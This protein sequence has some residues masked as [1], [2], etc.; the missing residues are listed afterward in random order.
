MQAVNLNIGGLLQNTGLLRNRN[1]ISR[2]PLNIEATATSLSRIYQSVWRQ[3]GS[4]SPATINQMNDILRDSMISRRVVK[5]SEISINYDDAVVRI[6]PS[7]ASFYIQRR[8]FRTRKQTFGV[9]SAGKTTPDEPKSPLTF[10][11]DLLV[12]K[13]TKA[14]EGGVEKWSQYEADLKKLP[15]GQQRTYTVA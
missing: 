12:G 7:T 5:K 4:A 3:F 8:G 13:K 15:E 2:K 1:G 14:T 10:F 11:S 6:V 9:G